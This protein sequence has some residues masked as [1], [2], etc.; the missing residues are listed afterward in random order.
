MYDEAYILSQLGEG[1]PCSAQ[2]PTRGG[3]GGSKTK[4]KKQSLKYVCIPLSIIY[5]FDMNGP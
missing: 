5:T 1:G 2:A 4:Q 3:G